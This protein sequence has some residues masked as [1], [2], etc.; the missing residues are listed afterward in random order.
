MK[1]SDLNKHN[2]NSIY[3]IYPGDEGMY[4]VNFNWYW[5]YLAKNREGI[6]A[7]L[8]YHDDINEPIGF[9]AYGV[10]YKDRFLKYAEDRKF[11]LYHIVIDSRFQGKRLGMI[12][13]IMA[14]K[15]IASIN[16]CD[17]ILVACNPEN[18]KATRMYK[19]LG[20]NLIG[21]NYDDDP[22]YSLS[23]SELSNIKSIK[24]PPIDIQ[25]IKQLVPK[26]WPKKVIQ[27]EKEFNWS[28]WERG[29]IK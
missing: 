14:L 15:E 8:I 12:S 6:F 4:W 2:I 29:L 20:F 23:T 18:V 10:H 1:T 28:D 25:K 19:S 13:T 22:L 3:K 9:M 26:D 11:E 7:K 17:E 24:V 27:Y 5:S 16:E 21:K